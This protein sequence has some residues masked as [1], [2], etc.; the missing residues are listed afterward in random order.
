MARD[1]QGTRKPGEA[2]KA[3]DY[4][5]RVDAALSDLPWS[6][7]RDLMAELKAHLEELPPDE[8]ARLGTPEEY[9]AEMRTAAGLEHRRG[10]IAFLRARR[11]R[12]LILT[13]VLLTLIGLAIG[14]VVWID[15][16]QPLAWANATQEPLASTPS[17]GQPGTTVVFRKGRPF[18]YGIVIRNSG[19]FTVRVLGVPRGVG[20]FYAGPLLMSK[21]TTPRM[22]ERPLERFHPFDMKP[23]SFRWLV[24]KG[25][26]ACTT[27]A[28]KPVAVTRVDFPIRY[29]FLWRTAIASIPLNDPV[30]ISFSKEGCPPP[31]NPPFK[32]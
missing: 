2:V 21:D 32:P 3:D 30:T 31:K 15:S 23:G 25:V 12:N 10:P 26:L 5:R 7:R 17:P 18:Q 20:D 6:V 28:S 1:Q 4:L 24:F 14:S 16:Y 9:A 19:R 29:S 11:P 8:A 27:G 22:D 13:V